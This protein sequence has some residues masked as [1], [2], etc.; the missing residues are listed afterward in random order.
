MDFPADQPSAD[1]IEVSLF[2]PGVGECVVLHVGDG[3]WVVVDSCIEVSGRAVAL[4][5]LA[6]LGVAPVS[7]CRV[8]ATHW[9]DDHI[10]GLAQ[11]VEK[12]A[13]AGFVCSGALRRKEF[14]SLIAASPAVRR[15]T[16]LASGVDEMTSVLQQ[17]RQTNRHPTWAS[18]NQVLWRNG[19]GQLTSLSP[20][21]ATLSRSMLGFAALAPKLKAALKTIPDV[22]PNE[23]SVA[24]HLQCG[25]AVVLLGADLEVTAA[26]D[27]G[28]HAV[29][30]S[31]ERPQARASTYKVAHHGS[32]TA[33]IEEIWKVLL[34]RQPTSM[35]SAFTRSHL[36]TD[37]DVER[38]KSLSGR[39]VQTGRSQ[40][41][42]IH[43]DPMVDRTVAQVAKRPPTPRRGRM[44][45]VR[46]RLSRST[47]VVSSIETFGAGFEVRKHP[48]IG[49]LTA[50]E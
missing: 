15:T 16:K 8:V 6:S 3:A 21:S 1:S 34:E 49:V 27:E 43:R 48:T 45:Q 46:V 44:G 17:L 26:G 14:L 20:S 50:D 39:L 31:S 23:T 5:Y 12:A 22:S 36:P 7:V 11:V 28:W 32:K 18:S 13:K 33:D 24:L 10:R 38:L 41:Q 25:K 9:H 35:V 29:L 37:E 19:A 4:E 30:A 2:G 47:G 42:A 40:V